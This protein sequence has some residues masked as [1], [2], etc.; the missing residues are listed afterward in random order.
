MFSF[1]ELTQLLITILMKESSIIILFFIFANHL[2]AQ[3]DNFLAGARSKALSD[4]T[5]ALNDHWAGLSNPADLAFLRETS[6]G[7][8]VENRYNIK[9]LYTGALTLNFML[10][11]NCFNLNFYSFNYSVFYSRQ[12]FG[13]AYALSLGKSFSAGIV[14][15][16]LRTQFEEYGTNLNY[17]GELGILYKPLKNLTVA[18]NIFNPTLAKYAGYDQEKTPTVMRTGAVVKISCN[19]QM[20][21][22]LSNSSLS[23]FS[24]KGGVENQFLKKFALQLGVRNNPFSMSFGLEFKIRQ[25]IFNIA[26]QY[27]QVLDTTPGVSFEYL[28][29]K[30]ESNH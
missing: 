17:C 2:L 12:K 22:E 23:G 7:L 27:Q 29:S 1:L 4:A 18:M 21:L 15:D 16:L 28:F 19:T 26:L 8:Y 3:S 9:E 6:A 25:L 11:G 30:P 20:M 10:S 13:L 5:V 14:I 24:F